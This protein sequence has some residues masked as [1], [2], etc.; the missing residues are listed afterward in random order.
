MESKN[1]IQYV[2]GFLLLLT[3]RRKV[4]NAKISINLILNLNLNLILCSVNLAMA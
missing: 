4:V 3:F 1:I 2:I